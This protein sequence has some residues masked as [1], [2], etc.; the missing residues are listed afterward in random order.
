MPGEQ[1]RFQAMLGPSVA[2]LGCELLGVQVSRGR[3]HTLLR[4]YIDRAEGITVDDCERVSHQVSGIL[5]VEDPIEGEYSLEVSSP[6]TDRPL[7]DAGHFRRFAGHKVHV[8]LNVPLD[9]RRSV[10]GLLAG[11]EGDDV[12]VQDG[13]AQWR[14]SI[15]QIAQARLVP[16]D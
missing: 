5:D 1:K 16:E 4:I 14:L 8:R 6:G 9:G 13:E 11:M 3:K 15:E 7:F 2:A 10:T 12:L